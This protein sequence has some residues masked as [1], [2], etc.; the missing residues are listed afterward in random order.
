M[1]QQTATV[2]GAIDGSKQTYDFKG[3]L[4]GVV[5]VK[6]ESLP[7]V[8]RIYAVVPQEKLTMQVFEKRKSLPSQVDPPLLRHEQTNAQT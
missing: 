7:K 3:R 1:F 8:K 5:A 6:P 2:E 4:L